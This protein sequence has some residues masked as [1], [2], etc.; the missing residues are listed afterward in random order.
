MLATRRKPRSSN[1]LAAN[2]LGAKI[3][4]PSYGLLMSGI[5]NASLLSELDA[6]S[7]SGAA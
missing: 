1:T 7:E 3:M 6:A 2:Y 5:M 4:A